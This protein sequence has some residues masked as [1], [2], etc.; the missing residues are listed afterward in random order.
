MKDTSSP[1]QVK[2]S[3]WA[4]AKLTFCQW[5]DSDFRREGLPDP[6]T[7]PQKVNWQR[8]LPFIFLH[9]GC[10]AV[11]WVGISPV[12]VGA[13]VVLYLVRMFA[14]TGFYHRYFSHKTFKTSRAAQF[15]FAVIGNSSMQRGPLWWAATH[16]H[17]H[18]HSDHEEDIH[19]PVV[20]GFMWSHIGWLTSMKNF[21]TAYKSIPDLSKFPELVFL[22]RYDQT[23]PFA[24]GLL[25]LAIGAVLEYGFPALGVTVGQFFIW[26]FFIS[27]TVLLH[28]TL[29]INS[30]AHVW[31]K[32]CY[33]T[34]DDSRNSWLLTL[35]TLGEG[36]HNNHH[37]YPHSVRQG[38]KWWQMDLTY[39]GLKFL[40]FT[41]LI[42]DLRPVPKAVLQEGYTSSQSR[43]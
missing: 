2:M 21:P 31:G 20:S 25:M 13:A 24:F 42:W 18:K 4:V 38:F 34:D 28:G 19:S 29:C 17:H 40:S 37:R 39:Y 1:S 3:S 36:W 10:L 33:E 43:A 26:T 11:F 15:A 35:I 5:L 9:L 14:I 7:L 23:V 32:K 8:T 30:M 27:T 22:N 6:A 16:R 12:S 41:G